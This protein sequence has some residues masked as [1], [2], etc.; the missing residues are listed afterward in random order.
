MI[1]TPAPFGGRSLTFRLI[2][3]HAPV[4]ARGIHLCCWKCFRSSNVT[5]QFFCAV[6][7]I[8]RQQRIEHSDQ[9]A[10]DRHQRLHLLQRILVPCRVVVM[11]LPELRVC[12]YQRHRCLE[13]QI[14]Q[15]LSTSSAD[16]R[17]ALMLSRLIV[18]DGKPCIFLQLFRI[19][20]TPYVSDLCEKSRYRLLSNSFD[21]QC[22][23]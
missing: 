18:H 13:E 2:I 6:F 11:Q 16:R 22:C 3:F 19:R 20:E 23:L 5:F 21:L 1:C 9:F 15:S 17:L 10:S 12:G 7:D 8:L 4:S 14:S